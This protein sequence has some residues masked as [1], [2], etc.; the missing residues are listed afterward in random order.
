MS[1]VAEQDLS[2][3]FEIAQQWK[4]Q[5]LLG[6]KSL[7]W[8]DDTI[9]T[10][11]NLDNFKT[12]FIDVP[13]TSSEKNFLQ[14]F[15]EQLAKADDNVTR[16]SCDLLLVYFLFPTSVSRAK[17]I[18]V[19]REVASWKKLTIDDKVPAFRGFWSG[20][21]D[22]GLTYNTGRPNELTYLARFAIEILAKEETD[23]AALLDDHVR[24]RELLE[25]LAEDH[26]EEF[27][28]PPQ[29]KHIILYLLFPDHYERIASEGHKGRIVD[30]FEDVI[31]DP[32]PDHVDDR[33]KAIRDRLE[34]WLPGEDLD[35]YWKPLRGCW[36]IDGE[37]DSLSELQALHIK[38][39]IVLFGPPGTGKTFQA[40]QLAEGL[41]R[42]ELLKVWTPAKFFANSGEVEKLVEARTHRVQFHPGYGYEDFIRGLQ[43]GD[44]GRTEYCDG[45]LL[46][47]IT[48]IAS[49][50]RE[51]WEVPVVLILD[52]MNRAD[53]SKVLG[54]CFSLLEDRDGDVTLAGYGGESRK[55]RLP[56]NLYFVGTMNLI[57][58]SLE[59]VDFALRRRFLWFF[60]G[61][62]PDD[63]ME[64]CRHRWETA[65]VTRKIGKNWDRVEG[66]FTVLG[67][68][69]ALVN[70]L[71]NASEYLGE[72]YQI[73]HTY[74]CDAV[75]FAHSYLL[76]TDKR[77]NQVLFARSGK[78]IEPVE[79]LWRY[80]LRP[81]LTQYL[82]G[83]DV[84]E[85]KA[86][87]AKVEGVLL[88]GVKI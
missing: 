74:F 41:I 39:Q 51:L 9:W 46:D 25:G 75:T 42:Q 4:K 1:R 63:F 23:R 83:V 13:D 7:I 79:A 68:R 32:K 28:R 78:A 59:N 71:I 69:A 86:F 50:P 40:R 87:L 82:A 61:F 24:L 48:K 2:S 81:L 22:P 30:A 44:G 65:T 84:S 12:F 35:F 52:E 14:K 76:A 47:L 45:V 16:L 85:G 21:G 64:V 60:K 18:E 31:E 5:S 17:K 57:D 19:I 62:S 56:R 33:L 54:E 34:S 38:K 20:V 36:Y 72:N 11:P 49:E 53:L 27:S 15:E 26:R 55:V 37:S 29:M 10:V 70:K 67:E 43:I 8:P 73:G 80:S 58:Q 77:R 66:E 6:G 3:I 88:S